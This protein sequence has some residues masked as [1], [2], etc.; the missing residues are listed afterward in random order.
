M[1]HAIGYPRSLVAA[2]C[3]GF[4]SG[5]GFLPRAAAQLDAVPE[6][7]ADQSWSALKGDTYDQ[8]DQFMAG[9]NR[10]S[11]KLDDQIRTLKAKRAG[12]TTDLTDWDIAMKDVD[13]GRSL[14][15]GRIA[16]IKAATTPETWIC[17]R[18]NFGDAWVKAEAAV[19]KMHTTVTS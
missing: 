5:V 17:A 11:A 9:V 3:L 4:L 12:M 8:R 15:T 7:T 14:L 1:K 19:D 2:L 18:D 16:D 6:Q 13:D 10:L